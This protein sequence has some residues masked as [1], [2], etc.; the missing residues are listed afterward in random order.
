[1]V[2]HAP[3]PRPDAA[4][5]EIVRRIEADPEPGSIRV[6]T[7]DRRLAERVR[8]AGAAVEG[9]GPFRARLERA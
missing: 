3:Q 7:S 8:S 4:D 5:D 6:V 9:A 1:V 2:A